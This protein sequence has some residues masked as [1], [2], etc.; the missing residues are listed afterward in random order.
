MK[1][2]IFHPNDLK[3]IGLGSPGSS[4]ISPPPLPLDIPKNNSKASPPVHTRSHSRASSL[5]GSIGRSDARR[6]LSG[7]SDLERYT[8]A[9]DEDYEDVFVKP[10]GNSEDFISYMNLS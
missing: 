6:T 4:P 1:K 8:E 10:S 7:S 5:G 3:T 2:G 9:E